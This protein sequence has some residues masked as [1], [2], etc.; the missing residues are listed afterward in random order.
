MRWNKYQENL[1]KKWSEMSKT[2]SIMHSITARYYAKW[3]KIFG[4]PAVLLGSG[5]ASSIFT[6]ASEHMPLWSYINGGMTLFITAI[7][8]LSNFLGTHEKQVKHTNAAFKYTAISMNI[9]TVLSFPRSQRAEEP[10]QLLNQMKLTILEI[11]EHTPDIPTWVI[12]NYIKK[13]DKVITD[14]RTKVNRKDDN[15]FL[16]LQTL[17]DINKPPS[18][19]SDSSPDENKPP[20][21]HSDS[22][23]NENTPPKSSDDNLNTPTHV[24]TDVYINLHNSLIEIDDSDEE[25]LL[26][27]TNHL[28]HADSDS[29]FSDS[30]FETEQKEN[31][32]QPSYTGDILPHRAL[33]ITGYN[34]ARRGSMS[35]TIMSDNIHKA[36]N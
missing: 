1:L 23:P 26:C 28:K 16:T 6:T 24:T 19:H 21:Q 7:I 36:C 3:E 14:T 32:P 4:I 27:I 15:S 30:E 35:R 2:Y 25:Q 9:D 11:R 12:N 17:Q 5:T 8:G 22:S 10:T 18:Q 33:S 31:L 34:K 29:D 13:L 20:S